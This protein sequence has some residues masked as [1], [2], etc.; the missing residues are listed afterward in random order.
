M[1]PAP[2]TPTTSSF[3]PS[4]DLKDMVVNTS[5]ALS[6]PAPCARRGASLM[7]TPGMN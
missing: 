5:M 7:G 6:G 1:T 3:A 2:S 4:E